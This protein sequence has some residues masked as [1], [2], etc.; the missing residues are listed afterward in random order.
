MNDKL[1]GGKWNSTKLNDNLQVFSSFLRW[2]K[3]AT[4]LAKS[5]LICLVQ[6][7]R[8]C[9]V[10]LTWL[11]NNFGFG[12]SDDFHS[13]NEKIVLVENYYLSKIKMLK[14]PYRSSLETACCFK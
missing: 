1:Y 8:F 5:K 4:N 12:F 3:D 7:G 11:K 10:S 6:I 13:M 2:S 14:I 9:S